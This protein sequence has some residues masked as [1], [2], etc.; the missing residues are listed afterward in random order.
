MERGKDRGGEAPGAEDTHPNGA[1]RPRPG[2]GGDAAGGSRRPPRSLSRPP[3]RAPGRAHTG[4]R[5]HRGAA[6]AAGC[7]RPSVCQPGGGSGMLGAGCGAGPDSPAPSP[8]SRSAAPPA[9]PE[10]ARP[11]RPPVTRFPGNGSARP[12]PPL[13]DGAGTKRPRR[14]HPAPRQTPKCR[15]L[16]QPGGTRRSAA[17]ML[18]PLKPSKAPRR[19]RTP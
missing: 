4:H 3:H 11:L 7:L 19:K 13:P 9:A 16:P 6:G 12:A 5:G 18:A 14:G 2:C 17:P 15:V 10:A 1:T 8:W